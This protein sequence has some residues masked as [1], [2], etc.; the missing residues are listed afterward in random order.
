[1]E[2]LDSYAEIIVIYETNKHYF[3]HIKIVHSNTIRFTVQKP[4]FIIKFFSIIPLKI[5]LTFILLIDYCTVDYQSFNV[6]LNQ[7]DNAFV[8]N[9]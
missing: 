6:S 5:N 4:L 8:E 9:Q 2:L 7:R 3:L 1:M